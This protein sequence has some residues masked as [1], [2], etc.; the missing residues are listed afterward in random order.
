MSQELKSIKKV[1]NYICNFYC[2]KSI[3]NIYSNL[4]FCL[5]KTIKRQTNTLKLVT[6]NLIKYLIATTTRK[7]RCQQYSTI[8]VNNIIESIIARDCKTII[9]IYMQQITK[10]VVIKVKQK[11]QQTTKKIVA[12]ILKIAKKKTTKTICIAKRSKKR[13]KNKTKKEIFVAKKT[14]VATKRQERKTKK[15]VNIVKQAK[16]TITTKIIVAKT[17]ITKNTKTNKKTIYN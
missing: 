17:K 16:Q 10:L 15:I 9:F 5:L 3:F 2:K 6:K 7:E 1:I 13:S 14:I 12:N 4:L 8:I 11:I